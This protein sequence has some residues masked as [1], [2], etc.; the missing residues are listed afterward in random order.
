MYIYA[1]IILY[2][3]IIYNIYIFNICI[4]IHIINQN[5]KFQT[6]SVQLEQCS[7]CTA[8]VQVGAMA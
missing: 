5:F 8:S 7:K 6:L 2:I 4:Y 3:Y 1:Y